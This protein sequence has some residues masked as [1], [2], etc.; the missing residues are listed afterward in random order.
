MDMTAAALLETLRAR[1]VSLRTDG[2]RIGVR[3]AVAL[4][5]MERQALQQHRD[6]VVRLL[7]APPPSP[8]L[9]KQTVREVLGPAPDPH[10]LAV[11]RFD[12]MAAVREIEEGICAGV[13]PPR[14]L[15]RGLPLCDWLSLDVVA[16]LLRLGSE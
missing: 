16:R 10:A 12:V 7:T 6:E 15:V 9:D 2:E 14:R 13:L 11:V 5:D 1:G 8:Y 4:T 3:P